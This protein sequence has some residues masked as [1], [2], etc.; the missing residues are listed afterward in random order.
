MTV[1]QNNGDCRAG[2]GPI[3]LRRAAFAGLALLILP[4]IQPADAEEVVPVLPAEALEKAVV[5]SGLAKNPKPSETGDPQVE[6]G[7]LKAMDP[8]A[9][10]VLDPHEGGFTPDL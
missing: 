9:V 4:L 2:I 8:A 3:D 6:T 1:F 5:R 10:G 7:E